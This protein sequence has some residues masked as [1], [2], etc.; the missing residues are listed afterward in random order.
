MLIFDINILI[1]FGHEVLKKVLFSIYLMSKNKNR[2]S[3]DDT[4]F[5]M[6]NDPF[7]VKRKYTKK[8]QVEQI[9]PPPVE[10]VTT[11]LPSTEPPKKTRRQVMKV[12]GVSRDHEGNLLF[13]VS[14]AKAKT[15]YYLTNEEMKANYATYLI[16]FYER[17][18]QFGETIN[19]N[20]IQIEK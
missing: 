12:H 16:G 8:N 18:I 11:M 15:F 6:P 9:L 17:H 20:S 5:Q 1:L 14:F 2:S 10:Q 7:R 3:D 13:A 4:T 19:I